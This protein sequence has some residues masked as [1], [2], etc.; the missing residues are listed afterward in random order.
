MYTRLYA[1]GEKY[2]IAV[3]KLTTQNNGVDIMIQNHQ[4]QIWMCNTCL[5]S[6]CAKQRQQDT[7]LCSI[8]KGIRTYIF[9]R[10]CM[11]SMVIKDKAAQDCTM[12]RWSDFCWQDQTNSA[13][14]EPSDLRRTGGSPQTRTQ[15]LITPGLM[16]FTLA[17]DYED[18]CWRL[19]G[20]SSRNI[21]K[22]EKLTC[23]DAS[24]V[25]YLSVYF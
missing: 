12:F 10:I 13:E 2:S 8:L 15:Q 14:C 17:H 25:S 16:A 19:K 7:A 9:I 5:S 3:Y 23:E 24:R 22:A 21:N 4:N 11:F 1:N 6:T 18:R 20:Q